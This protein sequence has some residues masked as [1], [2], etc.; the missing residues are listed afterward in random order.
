MGLGFLVQNRLAHGVHFIIPAEPH[1]ESIMDKPHA[2]HILLALV[3]ICALIAI[4]E[5]FL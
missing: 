2:Q 4:Y 3:V 5:V 1:K